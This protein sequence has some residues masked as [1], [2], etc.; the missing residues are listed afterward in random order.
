MKLRIDPL[1]TGLILI[2]VSL[3]VNRAISEPEC[4]KNVTV[5]G[6]TY[7]VPVACSAIPETTIDIL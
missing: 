7:T 2:V 3:G 1:L 4:K 5:N 6:E